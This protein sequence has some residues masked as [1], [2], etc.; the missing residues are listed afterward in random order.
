[1]N[2]E[3]CIVNIA[4]NNIFNIFLIAVIFFS[5]V[6]LNIAKHSQ[7]SS[8]M[9]FTLITTVVCLLSPPLKLDYKNT[10]LVMLLRTKN[11]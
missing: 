2:S 11:A 9:L 8:L 5:A 7:I 6:T 4:F 3:A 1:M 10:K